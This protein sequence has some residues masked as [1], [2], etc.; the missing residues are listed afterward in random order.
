ML[1]IFAVNLNPG[2]DTLA[3]MHRSDSLESTQ[4][5]REFKKKY[6]AITHRMVH[7]KSSAVMYSKILERTFGKFS[8]SA[9]MTDLSNKI[10]KGCSTLH[11]I[12]DTF[13]FQNAIRLFAS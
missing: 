3:P 13:Y 7:R 12:N 4:S 8:Y 5:E 11:S 1:I 10:N 9:A 2:D 6:Q